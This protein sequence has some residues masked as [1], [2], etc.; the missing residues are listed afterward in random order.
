MS[1]RPSMYGSSARLIAACSGA[2]CCKEIKIFGRSRRNITRAKKA[3]MV[4]SKQLQSGNRS[5]NN[6]LQTFGA[7]KAGP[8][9]GHVYICSTPGP[10]SATHKG[11]LN[12]DIMTAIKTLDR[13]ITAK[14]PRVATFT[15]KRKPKDPEPPAVESSGSSRVDSL[16]GQPPPPTDFYN[17]PTTDYHEPTYVAQGLSLGVYVSSHVIAGPRWV[18]INEAD[19]VYFEPCSTIQCRDNRPWES[20]LQLQPIMH[21][22]LH[23]RNGVTYTLGSVYNLGY[24]WIPYH[25]Q[26]PDSIVWPVGMIRNINAP[27]TITIGGPWTIYTESNQRY[28]QTTILYKHTDNT[29]RIAQPTPSNAQLPT[30]ES[31]LFGII[32]LSSLSKITQ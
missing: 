20:S 14:P 23:D 29:L 10:L 4:W 3:L 28:T 24:G 8:L 32:T 27:S 5:R 21:I 30:V 25:E 6:A 18:G 17:Q 26:P 13:I 2:G 1:R 16:L 11:Q 7:P 19:D 12:R 9:T 31:V 15:S 22:M